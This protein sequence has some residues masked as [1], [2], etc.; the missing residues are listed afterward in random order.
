M[1]LNKKS[2]NLYHIIFTQFYFKRKFCNALFYLFKNKRT[3][4]KINF[5]FQMVRRVKAYL[6]RM[7]IVENEDELM[8]LSLK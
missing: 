3:N 1:F 5:S 2:K 4:T 8:I 7:P 6:T